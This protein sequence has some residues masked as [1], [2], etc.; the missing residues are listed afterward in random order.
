WDA[1]SLPDIDQVGVLDVVGGGELERG[2]VVGPTQVAERIARLDGEQPPAP[3]AIARLEVGEPAEAYRHADPVVGR[4]H[5]RRRLYRS[6]RCPCLLLRDICLPARDA[7]NRSH[8]TQLCQTHRGS[9]DTR[10]QAYGPRRVGAVVSLVFAIRRSSEL[11]P[12]ADLDCRQ[13]RRE[14]K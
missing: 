10:P 14:V 11:A 13:R 3:A 4:T 9:P 7:R 12:I 8:T 1:E 2:R 6:F 5:V